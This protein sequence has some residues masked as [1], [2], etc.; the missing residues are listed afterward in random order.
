MNRKDFLQLLGLSSVSLAMKP[1][2]ELEKLSNF[3]P[4]SPKIPVLF[5]GHGTPMNAI[6]ENEYTLGFKKVAKTLPKPNAILCVSAHWLTRGTKITA[7]ENPR[8]IHDFGGF[9]QELFDVEYPAKGDEKLAKTTQQLLLP[10]N[11]LELDYDWGLDHGAWFVIKHL[12]PKADI[13]VLQLSIDY[14]KPAEYHFNLAKRLSKLRDKGVLIIGSGNIVHNIRRNS[15]V[16]DT[17]DWGEV[18]REKINE[19]ILKEDFNSLFEYKKLGKEVQYAIPTPDHYYP[20]LYALGLKEKSE[21][22]NIF[23]DSLQ[24]PRISMTSLKIT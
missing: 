10:N 6:T 18:A 14:Y 17:Q 8:T 11:A 13:P 2:S 20:L 4:N 3:F 19:L 21:T 9:P 5:L 1:V 24:N 23:N 7:M 12:Y 15:N 22:I 16:T